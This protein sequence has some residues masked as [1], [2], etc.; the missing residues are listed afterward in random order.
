MALI[1]KSSANN[2]LLDTHYLYVPVLGCTTS[3]GYICSN[4]HKTLSAKTGRYY[5]IYISDNDF[6]LY[7]DYVLTDIGLNA[8]NYGEGYL[9]PTLSCFN[10]C[11]VKTVSL[12]DGSIIN[13]KKI[14]GTETRVEIT[15]IH[16][17]NIDQFKNCTIHGFKL[18]LQ[19]INLI[20]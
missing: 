3:N 14:F 19:K 2:I 12:T 6:D 9:Y 4:S 20:Y 18:Y 10:Q 8:V 11:L 5:N 17:S 1:K 13:T 16:V 7:K 15:Q